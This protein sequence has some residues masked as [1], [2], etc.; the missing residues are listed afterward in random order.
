MALLPRHDWIA[1]NYLIVDH[2]RAVCMARKPHCAACV[3]RGLCP[4]AGML[5]S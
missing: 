3:L 4:S 1:F 5:Q 2:G